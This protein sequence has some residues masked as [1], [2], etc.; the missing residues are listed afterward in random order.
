MEDMIQRILGMVAPIKKSFANCYANSPFTNNIALKKMP[1]KFSFPNM[2]LYNGTTDPDNHI[3]QYRQQMFP[4][5]IPRNQ[6]EAYMLKGFRSSLIGLGLQWY[7][8]LPNNN[9]GSFAQLTDIFVEQYANSRKLEKDSQY[10]N[11]IKYGS[12]ETLREYIT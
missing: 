9:I 6:R 4:I 3:A 10:L 7:T 12:L 5:V 11:I 8:N 1:K 2:K